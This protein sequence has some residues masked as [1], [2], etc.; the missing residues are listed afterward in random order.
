MRHLRTDLASGLTFPVA[1][2]VLV[3]AVA[4]T[5]LAAPADA[6]MDIDIP[7]EK[8][9]LGNGLTLIVH[10][11]HKAPIVCVN[12]WYHVGSKNE[13]PG[14]TGF[15]HLFEHLMFNGSE[16]FDDD[17]F[18][19]LD[20]LGATDRNGTTWYDRTNYFQ[21]VPVTALDAILW[22]ESDRMGHMIGAITQEKLDEQRGVVQNE[23]RQGEDRPYGK[24]NRR[25][26]ELAYPK[27][28]PYSWSTI[29]SMEDLDAASL[30]DVHEWFETYY[31]AANAVLVVAGDVTA[32][33]VHAKVV[34][35]FG[36][37]PSGPPLAA[38]DTWVPRRTGEIREIWQDRVPQARITKAWN[39]PPYTDE[40]VVYLDLLSDVAG[41]GKNSRLYQRLVYEDQ[42]AT[43]VTASIYALEL[44]GI[45]EVEATAQP[46]HDLAAVEAAIDEEMDR[47]LKK[48]PTGTELERVR[49]QH[50]AR[51]L[52]GIERIG[53]FSGKAQTLATSQVYGDSPDHYKWR[54]QIAR[55]AEVEDLHRAG[56]QW[57][58]DG[59]AIIEVHPF[60]EYGTTGT[61]VDRTSLPSP[62]T[63]PEVGFPAMEQA[64][65]D[66]GLEVILVER[67]AVPIVQFELL[68]DAGY[69]ADHGGTLGTASLAMNLLDEGTSGRSSLEINSELAMI[70]ADLATSCNLDISAVSLSALAEH[71]DESLDIYADVILNPTFPE[72]EFTR[73]QREQLAA[74]Q[75]EKATPLYM[76]LRVFPPLLYGRD[77]AYG[78]PRTG[79]GTEASVSALTRGA[80]ADFHRTW[81]RPNN[82]TLIVVGATTLDEIVLKLEGL[83][84][85]WEPGDTPTKNVGVVEHRPQSEVYLIDKPGAAQSVILAGHIAPPKANPNEIAN[86]A[87]NDILG[88]TFTSRLN[89]NLREDKHWTYGARTYLLSARA[90][91]AF[92]AYAP[93]QADRTS[94][95]MLEIHYELAAIAGDEPPLADELEKIIRNSTLTLPGRWETA[96][97]V[98][99]S[100]GETIRYGLDA[101]H[102]TSYPD[103]VRDLELE[104]VSAAA[105]QVIRAEQLVWVVV[106]DLASIEDGIRALGLGAIHYLDADGNP[107]ADR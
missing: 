89:M 48:G 96:G 60:P 94:E 73:L 52:R 61:D 19:A 57:L 11:D 40:Q 74:I 83:L 59:A 31:G 87:V 80:L 92:M 77:H 86:E 28:H 55:S 58:G 13:K 91:R 30:E 101:D 26:T 69:A 65:L 105:R 100:I 45:F 54:L 63:F 10:E 75:R 20:R 37:I 32:E 9:V 47:L 51:F 84:S 16:H 70:G 41:L 46:G 106:G 107:A 23:K 17:Y 6:Q 66:N 44:G 82:A 93:V 88:G 64:T 39:I 67:R 56:Q 22:L 79:S 34:D 8:F 50:V 102:W 62:D 18:Q 97:A 71:L 78:L 29:G 98:A 38:M 42:I 1:A 3:A 24:A 76:G 43:S 85:S 21:N 95:A 33:E 27:G 14:K 90:Q 81:F 99:G 25:I 12:V 7:F 4:L 104:Q 5:A 53:G 72:G 103:R 2:V 49:T 15:A 36:D 68:V 35:C